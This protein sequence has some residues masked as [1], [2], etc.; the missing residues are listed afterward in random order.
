MDEL[1]RFKLRLEKEP[2][3][4]LTFFLRYYLLEYVLAHKFHIC[5][6]IIHE[7][8]HN[9]EWYKSINY[10]ILTHVQFIE[11]DMVALKYLLHADDNY[12]PTNMYVKVFDIIF[13]SDAETYYIWLESALHKKKFD[14]CC[15]ENI[16][17]NLNRNDLT[18]I[19]DQRMAFK[20]LIHK[21]P[22]NIKFLFM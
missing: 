14:L 5:D 19:C 3:C 7:Y 11:K 4:T 9:F 17:R 16:K 8:K 20:P 10:N 6:Y 18:R 12:P 13:E 22:R 15:I 21:S 1:E 2:N